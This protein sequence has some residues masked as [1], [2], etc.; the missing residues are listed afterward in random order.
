M[1]F[2]FF[3]IDIVYLSKI[4]TI[5]DNAWQCPRCCEL[6]YTVSTDDKVNSIYFKLCDEYELY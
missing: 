2:G 1:I 5:H 6:V 3:D 4:E